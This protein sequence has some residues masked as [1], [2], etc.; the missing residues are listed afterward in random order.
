[1]N[2]SRRTSSIDP[3]RSLPVTSRE[4]QFGQVWRPE[5][6]DLTRRVARSPLSLETG[7][8]AGTGEPDRTAEFFALGVRAIS[9]ARTTT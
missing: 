4:E 3:S 8:E 2:I 9:S 7:R 1:M 5:T 6:E